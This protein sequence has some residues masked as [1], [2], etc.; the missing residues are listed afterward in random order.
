MVVSETVMTTNEILQDLTAAQLDQL[1]GASTTQR[2][3]AGKRIFRAGEPAGHFYLIAEGQV[4][5]ET[6]VSERGP[7]TVDKLDVGDS[8]GWSW[9]FPPFRWHFDAVA[10]EP[11]RLITFDGKLLREMC[12][13]DHDLGYKLL[14]RIAGAMVQRIQMTKLQLTDMFVGKQDSKDRWV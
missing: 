10:L 13:A 5:L 8:L 2:F 3:E 6:F 9:L 12:E 11:V 4:G 7:V 1:S 14:N